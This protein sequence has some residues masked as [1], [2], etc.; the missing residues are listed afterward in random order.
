LDTRSEAGAM[1]EDLFVVLGHP[2]YYPRC[3]FTPDSRFGIRPGFDAPDETMMA[4]PLDLEAEFPRRTSE[5]PAP[6][7]V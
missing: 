4:L 3:G 2:E 7:G 5:Y 1:G 6:F